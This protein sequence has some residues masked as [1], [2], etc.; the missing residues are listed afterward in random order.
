[1]TTAPTPSYAAGVAGEPAPGNGGGQVPLE[2]LLD[3]YE[4]YYIDRLR[5]RRPSS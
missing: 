1:M 5:A 3:K 4:A 2:P